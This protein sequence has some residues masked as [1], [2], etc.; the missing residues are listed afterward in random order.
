MARPNMKVEVQTRT[1]TW[2]TWRELTEVESHASWEQIEAMRENTQARVE[3][4]IEREKRKH[5]RAYVEAADPLLARAKA[6]D[7]RARVELAG[8]T[9]QWTP[10]YLAAI[11]RELQEFSA[12]SARDMAAEIA[13]QAGQNWTTVPQLTDDR[14]AVDAIRAVATLAAQTADSRLNEA[15]RASAVQV[16]DGAARSTMTQSA[17]AVALSRSMQSQVRQAVSTTLNKTRESVS[18]AQGPSAPTAI[19]SAV[20]D[21]WTCEPCARNDG[22]RYKVG[23]PEYQRD[24]PP[25][26]LCRSLLSE[27][28][29]GNDCQ[30]VFVYE[31]DM[32]SQPDRRNDAGGLTI[33]T[34]ER[35]PMPTSWQ[36]QSSRVGA[37]TLFVGPPGSG[38]TS[39]A[40]EWVDRSETPVVVIDRDDY[41]LSEQG[42]NYAGRQQSID[43][44][45]AA[46]RAG[47]D[48]YY[49]ACLLSAKSRLQMVEWIDEVTDGEANIR[50]VS[51]TAIP[52]ELRRVNEARG[53]SD[54][55][56]IPPDQ[57]EHMLDAWEQVSPEE[58]FDEVS[59][60][61]RT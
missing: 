59:Y 6:G 4:A 56:S 18:L 52:D 51:V 23:S 37:V 25:Y 22:R 27:R 47:Y 30:C 55:G 40:R 42:Y 20:L 2:R 60:I 12:W 21:R 1:G 24:A 31:F 15:M 14:G 49:V 58:P 50:A 3:Q 45:E 43:D 34:R 29:Q 48:V 28:G 10:M 11:E 19:F 38:K 44:L 33:M 61:L 54:R 26:R 8:L 39:L 53:T 7:A 35:V 46:V 5:R 32:T 9:V 17:A 57:L 16:A 36:P 13:S 41:V